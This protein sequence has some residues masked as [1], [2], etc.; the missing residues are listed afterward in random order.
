MCRDEYDKKICSLDPLFPKS[1][2]KNH[3]NPQDSY[4]LCRGLN[5]G[6]SEY[7]VGLSITREKF[8]VTVMLCVLPTFRRTGR[9]NDI[10]L[11]QPFK[12]C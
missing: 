3:G 6:P 5:S 12:G 9:L 7:K 2:E 10:T 4:L 8:E 1:T 11:Y